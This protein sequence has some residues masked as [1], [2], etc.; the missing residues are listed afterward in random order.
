MDDPSPPD[1]A[2]VGLFR[3]DT[4]GSLSSR[5]LILRV[6]STSIS[7]KSNASDKPEMPSSTRSSRGYLLLAQ[8]QSKISPALPT[9][10]ITEMRK[11]LDTFATLVP[12]ALDRA[13]LTLAQPP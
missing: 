6:A 7:R 11:W 2:V 5:R 12:K 9:S 8:P 13:D 10:L 1:R 4:P 3:N